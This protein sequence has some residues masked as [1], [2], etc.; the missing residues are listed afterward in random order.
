MIKALLIRGAKETLQFL[1]NDI[2]MVKES[3]EKIGIEVEFVKGD[4]FVIL[5][6]LSETIDCLSSTDTLIVYYTGH[7]FLHNKT[8][9]FKVDNRGKSTDNVSIVELIE[10]TS[11]VKTENIVLIFD[12]C[13]ATAVESPWKN[14]A[15][16]NHMLFLP[17]SK[18]EAVEELEEYRASFFTY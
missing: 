3:F 11:S 13:Y 12:C 9:S 6:K 2:E 10:N 8:I 16:E 5:R 7:G 4:K 17:S 1:D 15:T 14:Y 18:L